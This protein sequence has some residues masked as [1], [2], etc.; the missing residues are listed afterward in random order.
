MDGDELSDEE[1]AQRMESGIRRAL[2]TPT[3][4][5]KAL[6]G[7]TECAQNQHKSRVRKERGKKTG[8]IDPIPEA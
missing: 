6:I 1:I 5:T 7:K 8:A 3:S 4:P 2:N